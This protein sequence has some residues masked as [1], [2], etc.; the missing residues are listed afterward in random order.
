MKG[1]TIKIENFKK[2]YLLCSPTRILVLREGMHPISVIPMRI[3]DNLCPLQK[4]LTSR[5]VCQ[6]LSPQEAYKFLRRSPLFKLQNQV[7]MAH[8]DPAMRR[9][10]N[11]NS[12]VYRICNLNGFALFHLAFVLRLRLRDP[13]EAFRS[14][15]IVR[16]D[17]A[18][19]ENLSV[20][21][22]TSTNIIATRIPF[23]IVQ[24]APCLYPIWSASNSC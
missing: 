13:S 16:T 18:L 17:P 3:M 22:D 20:Y 5:T 12:W 21:S 2:T 15:S 10:Y 7:Y 23:R 9:L 14:M 1:S 24:E 4:S 8:L 19:S 11:S 6:I